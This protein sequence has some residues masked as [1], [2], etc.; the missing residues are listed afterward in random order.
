[1][2]G[3]IAKKVLFITPF[4]R[5]SIGGAETLLDEI[6]TYLRS[7]NYYVYIVTLQPITNDKKGLPLEFDTNLEIRR[8]SWFGK[9]LFNKFANYPVAFNFLYLFPYLFIRSLIFLIK[10]HQKIDVID[11]HGLTASL[12]AK[13]LG[14]LFKKKVVMT[15]VAYY[16]FKK[17]SF[18]G[19]FVRWILDSADRI[20][21]ESPQSL[22]ELKGVGV[23]AAKAICFIEWIDLEKF[24]PMD[25]N[26]LKRQLKLPNKFTVL[27]VGR[28]IEVK[29]LDIIID[30]AKKAPK[31]INFVFI[32]TAG[33]LIGM[34]EDVSKK[35]EN[36]TFINGVEYSK[37]PRYYAAA[38]VFVVPSRMEDAPR[39]AVEAI[40]CGTPVIASNVGGIPSVVNDQIGKLVEPDPEEF[41]IAILDLY[42][43]RNKLIQLTKRCRPYAEKKYSSRNGQ[44]FIE[45]YE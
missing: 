25:K 18:L 43:N 26:Y 37:L 35:L 21:L 1:M 4:C 40:A 22:E 7:K 27:F 41:K 20:I 9:T 15:I 32:S 14:P 12:T 36:V 33:P 44:V 13:I 16:G 2:I 10:H 29:G 5:P 42:K 34:L 23:D 8:Y 31:E 17:R 19:Q 45:S 28:A 3:K 38:D 6:T 11:A 30:V 24:K 39:T